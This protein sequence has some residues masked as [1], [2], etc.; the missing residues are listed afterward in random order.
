MAPVYAVTL[1]TGIVFY[2]PAIHMGMI[3]NALGAGSPALI[4]VLITVANFA[5]VGGGYY[6]AR[7]RSSTTV[8]LSLLYACYGLGLLGMGLSDGYLASMPF[9]LLVNFGVGLAL[10]ILIGWALR[11]LDGPFRGR[12]MGL[13]MSSFFAAQ[14]IC[15]PLFALLIRAASGIA[16]ATTLVGGGTLLLA[17]IC[18]GIAQAA[19]PRPQ[20]ATSH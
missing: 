18:F 2:V 19:P 14:F 3:F 13:W 17:L 10:P 6:F 7:Q 16:A 11:N 9:A 1:L 8:N 15:P 4:A 5:S 12:G 20:P